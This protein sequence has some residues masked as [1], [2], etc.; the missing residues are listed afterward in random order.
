MPIEVTDMDEFIL[1]SE[2]A[3][4]CT[5]KKVKDIVKLKLRTPTALYTLKVEPVKTDEI[6]KKLKCDIEEI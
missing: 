5:V 3:K 1:L 4:H 6:F 2:R